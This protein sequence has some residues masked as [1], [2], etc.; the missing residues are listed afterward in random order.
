MVKVD[1]TNIVN[2][3]SYSFMRSSNKQK[4]HLIEPLKCL[5]ETAQQPVSEYEVLQQLQQLGW[6]QPID[7]RDTLSLYGAHFLIYNGL[8]QLRE[9]YSARGTALEISALSIQLINCKNVDKPFV[10]TQLES[11]ALREYYLDWSNLDEASDASVSALLDS[12]WQGFVSNDDYND[13]LRVL[14]ID[15]SLADEPIN[16]VYIKK[17]YRQ[18]AM[19]HHPDRGGDAATFQRIQSAFAIVQRHFR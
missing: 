12:F 3:A 11:E 1:V 18:L 6:L 10:S 8:Y 16:Y 15:S 4:N 14:A 13:A 19:K 9:Y 2:S 7:T 17:R 5:L